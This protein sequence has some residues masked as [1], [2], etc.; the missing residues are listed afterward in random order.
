MSETAAENGIRLVVRVTPRGGRDVI[1]GFVRDAKGE[2]MLKVRI[3]APPENGRANA[4][5][6]RLLADKFDVAKKAVT[7]VRGETARVKQVHVRG[8]A[9]NLAA[10]LRNMERPA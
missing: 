4:A 1:E 5:L 2:P 10:R 3:A 8:D 7:I 6:V 9:G